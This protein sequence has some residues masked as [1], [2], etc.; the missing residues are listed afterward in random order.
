MYRV[1]LHTHSE[2]SKDGGITAEQYAELLRNETLDIIAITDHGRIDFALGM[3]K[4]L[5][6]KRIIVGQEIDTS[7]GEIIGLFLKKQIDPGLSAEDTIAK[8]K[9]QGGV[10]YIPH[11][12]ETTRKGL[13]LNSLEMNMENIDIMETFNGRS[14]AQNFGPEAFA[15]ARKNNIASAASSDA[16]GYKGAGNTYSILM[17]QP[18]RDNITKLLKTAKLT[19]KSPPMS[20]LLYPKLNRFKK[21][22]TGKG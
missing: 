12:L 18:T 21:L 1:D 2:A 7:E 6:G 11:P 15:W 19:C 4:A 13:Q 20:S 9:N 22:I 17:E 16:H 5:G 10:V 8:I 3:Q 14:F